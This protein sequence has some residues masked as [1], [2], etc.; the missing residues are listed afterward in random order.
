ML[1][2]DHYFRFGGIQRLY[3]NPV[4]EAFA[5]AHVTVIGLGGV[6]SWA[7]E[8]LARSGIGH[9]TLIDLDEV[10]VS[11]TNRQIQALDGNYGRAKVEVMAERI[12]AINPSCRVDAR[13][14]FIRPDNLEQELSGDMDAIIDAIDSIRAKTALLAYCHRHRLPVICCGGAGGQLD[15][16]RIR[17]GDLSRTTQDPLLAKV[18][19]KLRREYGF[20]RNPQRRYG[21]ECV[22]STEQLTYPTP[23]GG[24]CLEK[25]AADGPVRLDCASG[26]GAST[27]VTATFGMFAAARALHRIARTVR[28]GAETPEAATG[29]LSAN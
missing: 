16:G 5:R 27:C 28:T 8:A 12:L 17:T 11:N 23:D 9:L 19:Q 4:T 2:D 3:G 1:S 18:R 15:P 26:F 29:E 13:L 24:V 21:I 14:R 6:G 22:F 7:A 10:C 25:P 20:S